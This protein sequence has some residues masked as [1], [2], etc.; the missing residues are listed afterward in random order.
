MVSEWMHTLYGAIR[1][2]RLSPP[3]ASRLMAY[4][5]TALYS[6]LSSTERGMPSL[7]GQAERPRHDVPAP[8]DRQGYDPTLTA[9]V[10]EQVVLDS[11]LS[12]SAADDAR[13]DRSIERLA[14][15]C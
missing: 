9:S 11:L 8:E 1:A 3:V 2:E 7:S 12:R 5:T 14:L 15:Q 13:V 4:A 6:G 10:A